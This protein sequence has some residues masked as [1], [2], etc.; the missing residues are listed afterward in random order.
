MNS[1]ALV[2]LIREVHNNSAKFV[3]RTFEM[4]IKVGSVIRSKDGL[5][6]VIVHCIKVREFEPSVRAKMTVEELDKYKV[7]ETT[8]G[9]NWILDVEG[10]VS[11]FSED[12]KVYIE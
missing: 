4:P 2:G 3:V 9:Q 7:Q 1:R 10:A 12:E 11:G 8:P 5:S 6:S